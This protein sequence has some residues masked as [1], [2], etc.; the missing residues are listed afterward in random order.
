MYVDDDDVVTPE[1]A[2]RSAGLLGRVRLPNQDFK[3]SAYNVIGVPQVCASP[4]PRH[5]GEKDDTGRLF[6]LLAGG[7]VLFQWPHAGGKPGMQYSLQGGW[8]VVV[9]FEN[10]D[11]DLH[12]VQYA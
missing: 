11:S 3:A 4:G 2:L 7:H 8:A 9:V 12:L 6:V 10:H 5:P 1:S